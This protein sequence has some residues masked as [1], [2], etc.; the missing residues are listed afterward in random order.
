MARRK[1][2]QKRIDYITNWNKE[3][4]TQVRIVFRNKD[5]EDVINYIKGISAK[6]AYM[7]ELIRA[8]MK[9]KGIEVK[10]PSL[11]N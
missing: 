6:S 10:E 3:N 5:D 2:T 4:Q 8:D 11:K 9:S 7:K 1:H